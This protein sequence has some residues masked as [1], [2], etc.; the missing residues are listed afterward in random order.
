M[1]NNVSKQCVRI[2][3]PNPAAMD[4]LSL[5]SEIWFHHGYV[6]KA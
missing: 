2:L 5:E 3:F 6:D 1:K 4:K